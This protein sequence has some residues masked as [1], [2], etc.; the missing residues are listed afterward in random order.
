MDDHTSPPAQALQTE[1]GI[2]KTSIF[3]EELAQDRLHPRPDGA[4][5]MYTLPW[6]YFVPT[7]RLGEKAADLFR[8]QGLTARVIRS[9]DALSEDG[10]PMCLDLD[11]VQLAKDCHA[12]IQETCCKGKDA[13]G[14]EWCCPVY[15]RGDCLYQAQ[16][17]DK[18]EPAP[19]V[20][21]FAHQ[22]MFHEHKRIG[23]IA[24]IGIDESFW[25]SGVFGLGPDEEKHTIRID[26]IGGCAIAVDEEDFYKMSVRPQLMDLRKKLARALQRQADVGG[27][28]RG[29]L[30]A[31]NEQ[32]H[33][34]I[35]DHLDA[36]DCSEAIKLE[37][38]L[39]PKLD[40]HPG[41]SAAARKIFYSKH[42]RE[43]DDRSF[44]RRMIDLWEGMRDLLNQ[45][46]IAVSGRV[47]IREIGRTVVVRGVMPVRK[48]WQQPVLMMDATLPAL[49]ML[50]AYFPQVQIVGKI[51]AAMPHAFVRQVLKA[52]V[53]AERLLKTDSNVNRTA[54]QRYVL[55]RWIETGRQETLVVCQMGYEEW[56]KPDEREREKKLKVLGREKYDR[57]LKERS[58]PE[59]IHVEHFN[60]VAGLDDYKHV[61]LLVTVGRVQP[62]PEAAEAYAGAM[63]GVEPK[64][65]PHGKWYRKVRRGI[66]LPD[67]SG[68]AVD[69]DE[70]PDPMVEMVRVQL[71]EAEVM[72]AIGRG[73]GVNRTDENPLDID[74]VADVCLD[75]TVNEV[76]MW[77]TQRPSPMVEAAA[78]GVVLTSPV[79]MVKAWPHVWGNT[80]AADRT[81]K[82]AFK[83][84]IAG[85]Q[86]VTYQLAG[87][88]MK[89]RVGYF[90]RTL[91]SD[92]RAWLEERLGP[93]K[94]CLDGSGAQG[95]IGE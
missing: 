36:A 16:F 13:K 88:K 17:P 28:E 60:N 83:N 59:N 45:D 27:F 15:A 82:E 40:I 20:F 22:I 94:V 35:T 52:P 48:Q 57:W 93:L 5:E 90:D 8:E 30:D 11:Q 25:E 63:T 55:K 32:G 84:L 53:S 51:N 43:I 34:V 46:D 26:E 39:M 65:L 74:I 62:G 77:W 14:R 56:L 38:A 24:A 21:I 81:L 76:S 19:D 2:G 47:V 18:G 61:R 67:G 95:L 80:I 4:P 75:L 6:A 58:L 49:P 78:E 54:L 91:I 12:S 42:R 33:I 50:Q 72:Q 73:R 31:V 69:C 89:Q 92:P 41:M 1:T 87:A 9:R 3:V 7:H 23:E 68:R 64:K 10:K 37:W 29:H 70:H 86:P 71:C 66:R 44:A 79:D 85:W